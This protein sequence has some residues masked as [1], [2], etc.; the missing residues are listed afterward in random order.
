MKL[1]YKWASKCLCSRSA[2]QLCPC[3]L[4]LPEASIIHKA[5]IQP[6]CQCDT[7]KR[8]HQASLQCNEIEHSPANVSEWQ[9]VGVSGESLISILSHAPNSELEQALAL[10]WIPS[11]Y[12]SI[13]GNQRK[14]GQRS[15]TRTRGSKE[16][17]GDDVPE[18][19]FPEGIIHQRR[20][21]GS[22]GAAA[23][24]GKVEGGRE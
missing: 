17:G 24:D 21:T 9:Q 14:G 16:G 11:S 7:L 23:G 12:F 19:H 18:S 6:I 22:G 13:L 15:G 4:V 2:S 10:A 20:G 8:G 3:L 1:D 5:S